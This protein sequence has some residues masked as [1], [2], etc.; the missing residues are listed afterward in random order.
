MPTIAIVDDREAARESL[1]RLIEPFLLD[2]WKCKSLHPFRTLPEYVGFLLDDHEEVAVLILD[3]KLYEAASKAKVNVDYTGTKLA[4]FIRKRLPDFPIYLIT[5]YREELKTDAALFEE[6]FDRTRF[7]GEP[8]LH[9]KR[10]MRAGSRFTLQF[11]N[12]L[13]EL[14]RTTARLAEGRASKAEKKRAAAI[15]EK[16]EIAFPIDEITTRSE[17]LAELS[18]SINT[19]KNLSGEI[20]AALRKS[21][22]KK[23]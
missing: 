16:L 19:L 2:G 20:Q 8:S 10:M 5:S 3:E 7:M 13:N 11:E 22:K 23:A 15:R 12:E 6:L 9:V 1:E 14:S 18:T 4:G 17:W 21:K